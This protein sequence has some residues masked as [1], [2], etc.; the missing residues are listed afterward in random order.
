M[1]ASTPH[2]SPPAIET[3]TREMLRLPSLE[4]AFSLSSSFARPSFP[5]SFSESRQCGGPGHLAGV[6]V[7]LRGARGG[8]DW[9]REGQNFEFEQLA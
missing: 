2:L 6:E 1:L 7:E 3:E 4:T 8:G 5:A 9:R